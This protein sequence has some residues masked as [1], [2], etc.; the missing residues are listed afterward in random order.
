MIA[1]VSLPADR[2]LLRGVQARCLLP[3]G[4]LFSKMTGRCEAVSKII[5]QLAAA[6]PC[7]G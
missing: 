7:A 6:H 2:T 5:V 3:S 4:G 1:L